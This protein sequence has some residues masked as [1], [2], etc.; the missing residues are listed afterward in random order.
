MGHSHSEI[1][2]LIQVPGLGVALG[3]PIEQVKQTCETRAEPQPFNSPS[4]KN[5]W[6]IRLTTKGIWLFSDQARRIIN[7]R[8]DP[9]FS[10]EVGGIRLKDSLDKL[11]QAHGEPMRQ[12][13]FGA[14]EAY[15]YPLV[16][17]FHGSMSI[18]AIP[19]SRS[20]RSRSPIPIDPDQCG[21]GA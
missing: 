6:T 4:T 11:K 7:I 18:P 14:N 5:G 19:I 8:L 9:P 15:L 2:S 10:G 3:D 21:V 13:S 1:C 16:G 12:W 17:R 20:R